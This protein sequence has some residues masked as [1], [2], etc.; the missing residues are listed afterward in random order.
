L[1]ILVLNGSPR[2]EMSVSYHHI[3][4]LE[5]HFKSATFEFVH[6]GKMLKIYKDEKLGD[7]I[8][9]MSDADCVLWTY[10]VYTFS[11]PYQLMLFMNRLQNH[12]LK[13]LLKGTYSTQ[14][15]TSKHFYDITAYDFMKTQFKDLEII[16]LEGLMADMDEMITESGRH[17]MVEFMDKLLHS[18]T[19]EVT[20]P[21]IKHVPGQLY[22]FSYNQVPEP[23][24]LPSKI[25]V[26]YNGLEYSNSLKQMIS[27]FENLCDYDVHRLDV[28]NI[29]IQGGC[30]G[31]IKCTM[32]GHCIY[33]DEFE[34]MYQEKILSSDVI[35][36]A[37]DINNHYLHADFKLIDDRAFYNGHRVN[38]ENKATGYLLTGNYQQE[39]NL[40]HLIE[41]RAHVG[42]MSLFEPVTNESEDVL[43]QIKRLCTEV[44]YFMENKPA[45]KNSFYGIGGMKVF[46]DLIFNM[47]GM[48]T[49][50][51]DYYKAHKLYDFPEKHYITHFFMRFGI[52]YIS[53]PKRFKKYSP[54][55]NTFILARY[56]KILDD[57]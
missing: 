28:S 29:N 23:D 6:I 56:K 40:K 8:K 31:C 35:V 4:F 15:S 52:K 22:E 24:K 11:I 14:F 18:I 1:K 30:L 33:K 53:S 54:K 57:Y 42:H 9:K 17:K 10:P 25:L 55:L 38:T 36:Y 34:E 20:Y 7:L 16:H 13:H 5:K 2:G 12:D 44:T 41:A 49:E 50:D 19:V 43:E 37:S 27:A 3:L 26:V 45:P 39:Q 32:I 48:L 46:R 21:N 47:R 51:H